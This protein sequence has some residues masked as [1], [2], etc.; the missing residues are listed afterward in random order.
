MRGHLADGAEGGVGGGADERVCDQGADGARAREGFAGP[1]EKTCTE[2]AGDLCEGVST[3]RA[4]RM[5][6]H[7]DGAHIANENVRQSSGHGAA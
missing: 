1:K 2:R 7:G 6:P 5:G 4:M 3:V